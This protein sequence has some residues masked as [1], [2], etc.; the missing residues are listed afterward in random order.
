MAK[1]TVARTTEAYVN[2]KNVMVGMAQGAIEGTID[3]ITDN[4][5]GAG[6]KL[7]AN[8]VGET[9][10]DVMNATINNKNMTE[11]VVGGIG[12]GLV[13]TGVD[14]GMDLVGDGVKGMMGDAAEDAIKNAVTKGAEVTKGSLVDGAK[15]LAGD[16][17]KDGLDE[18]F[19][20]P[21]EE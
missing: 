17:V 11:A 14:V 9:S 4:V 2:D 16:L 20:A 15:T 5:D 1:N 21:G 7:V 19:K 13:N 6:N 12:K 3:V 18:A 10:K 8:V